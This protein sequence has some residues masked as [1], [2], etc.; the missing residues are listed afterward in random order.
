MVRR[1]GR[2]SDELG[3]GTLRIPDLA[4][5]ALDGETNSVAHLLQGVRVRISETSSKESRREV[6]GA[7]AVAES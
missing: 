3:R 4:G 7:Q 1:E 6:H 2:I 5:D